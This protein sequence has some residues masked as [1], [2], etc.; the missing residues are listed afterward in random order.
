MR[1]KSFYVFTTSFED[2]KVVEDQA[3][4]NKFLSFNQRKYAI[5]SS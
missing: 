3:Q 1:I 4:R 5:L 2:E